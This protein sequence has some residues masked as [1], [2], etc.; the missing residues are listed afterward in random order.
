VE[1]HF[2]FLEAYRKDMKNVPEMQVL[3]GENDVTYSYGIGAEGGTTGPE[4]L[5]L[6]L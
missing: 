3:R 1:G 2:R 5:E 4:L 6:K